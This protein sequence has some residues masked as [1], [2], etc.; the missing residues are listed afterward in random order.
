MVGIYYNELELGTYIFQEIGVS[1]N[2]Y[3]GM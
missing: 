2:F 3:E 1:E